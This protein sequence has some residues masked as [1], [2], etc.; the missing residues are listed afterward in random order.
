VTVERLYHLA[1]RAEWDDAATAG[2]YRRSTLGRSLDEVGFIHCSHRHQVQ[3]IADL[4]YRGRDDVVLLEIDPSL[5][6]AEVKVEQVDAKEFPHI[7]GDLPA[8]AVVRVVDIG[9]DADGRL[10]AD[11]AVDG[12]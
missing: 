10:L 7:Y 12:R 2:V 9:V 6:E 1:L 11:A 3:L 8:G 4:V 5:V